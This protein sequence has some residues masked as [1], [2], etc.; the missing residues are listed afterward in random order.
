[1]LEKYRLTY[2]ILITSDDDTA[3]EDTTVG[4]DTSD[5]EVQLLVPSSFST[6]TYKKKFKIKKIYNFCLYYKS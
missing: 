5:E 3:D 1:M 6:Q 4:E 2:A